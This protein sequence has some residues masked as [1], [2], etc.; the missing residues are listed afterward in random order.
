[1]NR[2][3]ETK[4]RYDRSFFIVVLLIG[5]LA[6][7]IA[8]LLFFFL[9]N[10]NQSNLAVAARESH[11]G[12]RLPETS[13]KE[14]N[15]KGT[16]EIKSEIVT[17]QESTLSLGKEDENA[18][19]SL[20]DSE[21]AYWFPLKEL[22]AFFEEGRNSQESIEPLS[23]VRVFLDEQLVAAY[24]QNAEGEEKL[25][26]FFPCSSGYF[27]NHTPLG[28]FP[29]GNKWEV[30]WLFD[31]SQA[32][33]AIQITGDILFHSLPSYDGNIYSGLKITDIN[34][35]GHP[36]SHGCVR[37]FCGDAKW[38][39]ERCPVGTPIE[40]LQN[41]GEKFQDL[42][43][44]MYYFRLKNGAPT[45][46]PT[47]PHPDNPYHDFSVLQKWVKD[48]PWQEKFILI[49]P[50]WPENR[51]SIQSQEVFDERNNTAQTG[52]TEATSSSNDRLEDEAKPTSPPPLSPEDENVFDLEAEGP[53]SPPPLKESE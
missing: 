37:L 31:N 35:I 5:I 45:W 30:S 19:E 38:L 44:K 33:Y 22:Y 10:P 24:R 34:S 11:S 26:R 13:V 28:L 21:K 17:S 1:M 6:L 50:T 20:C 47:D 8:K 9:S 40:I 3:N 23:S 12:E 52:F 18:S 42:P 46:D 25:V 15:S 4:K 36:A 48:E 16:E 29:A 49:P 51:A 2:Y 27:A 32:Q 41:R 14:W 39:Y 53:T 7:T 43:E